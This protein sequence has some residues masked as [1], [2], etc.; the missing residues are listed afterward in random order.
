M[1]IKCYKSNEQK[2]FETSELSFFGDDRAEMSLI[3]VY[4]KETRQTILG[5]GGAFTE[6]AAETMKTMSVD[7]KEQFLQAC[8]GTEGN[9]YNFCRTHIQ[10]CDF[11]LGNYA[12]VEDPSDKNLE[13]F[14][15]ERDN[16]YLIPMIKDALA[17][18]PDIQLLASPWSPPAFMKSN[19]EMNH[20]GV[21]KKEYYQMWADMI[22]KY[23]EEYEKLGISIHR[24]SVQ[25]EP[26]A[27]QT[28][29]SC[30]YTGEEEGI[31]AT[32]YLRKTLDAHGY[33]N[34]VIVI[35]D[36]NK[37]CILERAD[38]TFSVVGAKDSVGAIGFHWYTGDH[39]EALDA[40]RMKYPEKEL[41]FTEGCVEYSRFKSNNQ[42]KNAEMYLHDMIGNLNQ[43]MNGYIDWNLVLNA[44]GGPNHVGNFCDAPIMYDKDND[45]LD[46]KLSFHYIGHLSRFVKKGAKRILVSRHTDQVDAVGFV[47][48]DGEKVVVLMNRTENDLKMQVC[49][50][51]NVCDIT[52]TA[53]SVITLCW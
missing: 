52:L 50:D 10:S 24:I 6:A 28:W 9:Q 47:N 25:N 31:F 26:K 3:K 37:D 41:I 46:I 4:P 7:K 39:F 2:Q 18:N 22:V 51:K 36:H 49:E 44:Q 15:L 21:L 42:V 19:Q 1:N 27:T 16:Q 8:F 13:T 5:F 33:S 48:P 43:G 53:H 17:I 32:K 35:W 20:G 45:Q 11:A 14:T 29:D 30:L 38:E 40:V 34:I 12:Y 23:V